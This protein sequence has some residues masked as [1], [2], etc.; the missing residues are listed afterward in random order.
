MAL[1]RKIKTKVT[2]IIKYSDDIRFYRLETSNKNFDF[3][4]GQF[5]Q[6][7]IDE[8]DASYPWPESRC[9]SI[10]SSPANRDYIDILVS[11]KGNFTN[12]MFN[13][14]R[15]NDTVWIKLPYGDFNFDTGN[16]KELFFIAGGTGISPFISFLRLLPDTGI[17]NRISLYYGVRESSLIIFNDL[18]EEIKSKYNDIDIN[19]YVENLTASGDDIYIKG[20]LPVNEIFANIINSGDAEVYLS[21]PPAMINL[22]NKILI[23]K[24]FSE[25]NIHFD[26]WE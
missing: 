4:C 3:K 22:F 20:I 18:F 25:N 13:E 19:L 1:V 12:R 8:Y 10:I 14:L 16:D 11:R 6:L 15:L 9:F 7:A 2:D 23:E 26:K 17:K 24:G 5:L 21:G